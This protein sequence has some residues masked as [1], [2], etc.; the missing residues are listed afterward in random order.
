MTIKVTDTALVTTR[1]GTRETGS[2]KVPITSGRGQRAGNVIPV[3]DRPDNIEV[4][5]KKTFEAG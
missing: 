1:A 3:E 2:I 4:S 5:T